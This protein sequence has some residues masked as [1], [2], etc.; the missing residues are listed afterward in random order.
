MGVKPPRATCCNALQKTQKTTCPSFG[1]VVMFSNRCSGIEKHQHSTETTHQHQG[2]LLHGQPGCGK[3][4]VVRPC[5][6]RALAGECRTSGLPITFFARKV[7][8]GHTAATCSQSGL[9]KQSAECVP[10]SKS[11]SSGPLPSSSSMRCLKSLKNLRHHKKGQDSLW[12]VANPAFIR[13]CMQAACDSSG[14][15]YFSVT[16]A[17]TGRWLG[18]TQ[19]PTCD[20]LIVTAHQGIRLV[21][22]SGP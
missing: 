6:V 12:F 10:S 14:L 3:T 22:I 4:L 9:A 11:L 21:T 7:V 13:V 8:H 2:V 17:L 20:K 19:E 18:S 15:I 5:N 1:C 16:H